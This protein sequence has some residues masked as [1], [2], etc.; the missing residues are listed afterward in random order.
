VTFEAPDGP[1][2]RQ[3]GE[4]GSP[5]VHPFVQ[6]GLYIV[7]SSHEPSC[8]RAGAGGVSRPNSK[9]FNRLKQHKSRPP[10]RNDID[11]TE[12]HRPWVPLWVIQF[13]GC[14]QLAARLCESILIGEL[15]ANFYFIPE[16]TG[17]GFHASPDQI[18]QIQDCAIALEPRFG[19][20]IARQADP[21]E[22]RSWVKG[23]KGFQPSGYVSS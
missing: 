17:S 23:V 10:N 6:S 3:V 8:F 11:W 21:V 14:S 7:Q 13:P 2:Y 20:V 4:D 22:V 5:L 19:S 9:V 15:A 18:S 16:A 1:I 12:Y